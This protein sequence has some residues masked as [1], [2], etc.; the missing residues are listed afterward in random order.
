M[1]RKA[2]EAAKAKL[3]TMRA[4]DRTRE[5]E[6]KRLETSKLKTQKEEV[7]LDEWKIESDWK[8]SD[9]E[10]KRSGQEKAKAL[11]AKAATPTKLKPKNAFEEVEGL[12][13]LSKST[14]GSYVKKAA[15]DA[16]ISRK[17][18]SDFEHMA[19]RAKKPSMKASAS[20]LEK[21]Y[22][23]KSWKRRDNIGKAVD[24]LT[25]EE[26]E[27]QEANH[28]DFASAGKMH[29]DMAKNMVL[30]RESDYYE[31]K[32]GDKVSGKV[33]HNNGKEVHVKQTHDSYD[34][35]KVG[36]LHKFK[37]SIL[38]IHKNFIY[39]LHFLLVKE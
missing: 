11:A 24:R 6:K 5:Y 7:D 37:I 22:K 2:T 35:K 32:T 28:R 33:I 12:D 36:T 10:D 29:P 34:P 14:L 16:T 21:E 3:Q 20:E 18:A 17:V 1:Y 4:L 38:Q 26:V 27:I 9:P 19:S 30:G 23:S 39:L 13:E 31:P 25:K 8:K 15:A